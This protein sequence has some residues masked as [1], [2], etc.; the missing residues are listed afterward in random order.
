M[1]HDTLLSVKS[2]DLYAIPVLPA[3][4]IYLTRSN[5]GVYIGSGDVR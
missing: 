4:I 1:G 5:V 3:A 2:N